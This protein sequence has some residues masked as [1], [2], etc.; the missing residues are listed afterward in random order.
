VADNN[1]IA[2]PYAEAA[3]EVASE[4]GNLAGWSAAL[5]TAGAVIA[6]GQVVSFLAT[7]ALT[8]E[9]RLQFLVELLASLN[10]DNTVLAGGDAKGTN[11]IKLLLE[12]GRIAVLPEIAEHFEILKANVENTVDVVVTSATALSDD[13]RQAITKALTARLGR[14]VRLQTEIDE[15]LIGGAVIRAGDIVIDGSLRARLDGL[16]NALIA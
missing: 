2:R 6:D 4:D 14:D 10:S 9:Q 1:T 13:Q 3:F 7:P 12:Y 8:S 16:T 15:S 5:E 11:F